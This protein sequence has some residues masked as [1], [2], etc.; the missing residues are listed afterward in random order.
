M[1]DR[2]ITSWLSDMDGVLVHDDQALPGAVE[3]VH[4]LREKERPFLLLTN[5]SLFT[6]SNCVSGCFPAGSMYRW[7]LF[8]LRRLLPRRFWLIRRR[9]GALTRLART[10]CASRSKRPGSSTTIA[11]RTLW[12]WVRITRF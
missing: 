3:F 7:K 8:G 4:R 10:V 9:A 6:P 12:C 11:I 2:V 1:A 5:N